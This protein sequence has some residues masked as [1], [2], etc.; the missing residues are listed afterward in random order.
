MSEV[1]L[2]DAWRVPA[3]R[4]FVRNV[5]P[6]YV[7]EL[8]GFDTDFYTLDRA[9]RWQPDIVDDWLSRT[10]P[11]ANVRAGAAAQD[12]TEPCQRTHVI[13]LGDRFVGFACVGTRPFRYMPEDVDFRLAELFLIHEGRG[14][15]VGTRA[16][17]LLF[18]RYPGSWQLE[19]IHDNL[20][21][22]AFWR[23]A[24]LACG[25]LQL[26]E[27][28]QE[29]EVIFRFKSAVDRSTSAG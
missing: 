26:A 5:W 29:R 25:V 2:I 4:T 20:R 6:M 9:G 19:I 17:E 18:H 14:R 15:G 13:A 7:H 21:A 10:T 16:V 28:Q 12:F 23:K 1:Q 27:S 3:A 8:S 11:S 24:L 22:V